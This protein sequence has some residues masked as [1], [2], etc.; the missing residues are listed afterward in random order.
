M[1]TVL[2]RSVISWFEKNAK[3]PLSA[4]EIKALEELFEN[5]EV[6]VQVLCLAED[7]DL[8]QEMCPQKFPL[9]RKWQ[10]KEALKCARGE[11]CRCWKRQFLPVPFVCK[12]LHEFTFSKLKLKF[13]FSRA[14]NISDGHT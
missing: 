3:V 7:N 1:S 14:N 10:L 11:Y 2:V 9:V 6:D 12:S 8:L 5:E 13:K 4:T